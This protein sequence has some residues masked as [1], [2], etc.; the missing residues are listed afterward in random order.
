MYEFLDAYD[1]P[2]LNPDEVNTQ[3]HK[4]NKK[5]KLLNNLTGWRLLAGQSIWGVELDQLGAFWIKCSS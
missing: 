4:Y 5:R 3:T 2:K 1:L